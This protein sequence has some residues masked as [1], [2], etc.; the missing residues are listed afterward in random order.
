MNSIKSTTLNGSFTR[1]VGELFTSWQAFRA[2]FEMRSR[3]VVNPLA[4]V[5]SDDRKPGFPR[6][7]LEN[8]MMHLHLPLRTFPA[9]A[10]YRVRSLCAHRAPEVAKQKSTMSGSHCGREARKDETVCAG[11]ARSTGRWPR[12]SRMPLLAT[13]VVSQLHGNRQ[14]ACFE[15]NARDAVSPVTRWCHGRLWA[16][17]LLM[18][19]D[20]AVGDFVFAVVERSRTGLY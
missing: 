13:V 3:L 12:N 1:Y 15:Y 17:A 8:E 2:A 9:S 16:H 18:L 5:K 4:S 7:T 19:V 6:Q 11:R 20:R 14:S 10:S